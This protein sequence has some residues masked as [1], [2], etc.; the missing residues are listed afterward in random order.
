MRRLRLG[1]RH[2]RPLV[3]L[4]GLVWLGIGAAVLAMAMSQYAEV[5]DALQRQE[6]RLD[7]LREQLDR[8]TK[9]HEQ[10]AADAKRRDPELREAHTIVK[11]LSIP[12]E[13]V[14]TTLESATRKHGGRIR[15]RGIQPDVEKGVI[16]LN[17]EAKD[18]GALMDYLDHVE[19]AGVLSRVRLVNHQVQTGGSGH[20]VRFYAM[21]EWHTQ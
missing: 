20:P 4:Q 17:G 10:R 9:L 5:A 18:F 21:A 12:W 6:S 1:Y 14:F 19:T 3:T 2:R 15:V 7:S 11:R 13:E 16:L 8:K